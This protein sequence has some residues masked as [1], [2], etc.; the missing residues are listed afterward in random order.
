VQNEGDFVE[1]MLLYK[2]LVILLVPKLI[3]GV[4]V[5]LLSLFP[6]MPRW[7]AKGQVYL[8]L[9]NTDELRSTLAYKFLLLYYFLFPFTHFCVEILS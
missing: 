2:V 6:Y 1:V 4:T 3:M 8:Y 5:L 9:C 7:L